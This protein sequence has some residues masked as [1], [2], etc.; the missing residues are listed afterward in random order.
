MINKEQEKELLI[1]EL[2]IIL[3]K[4]FGFT[5]EESNKILQDLLL[6]NEMTIKMLKK[7]K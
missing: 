4:K 7:G 3:F 1:A 6:S 5:I 2:I